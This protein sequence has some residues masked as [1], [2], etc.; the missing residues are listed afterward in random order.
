[1]KQIITLLTLFMCFSLLNAQEK[2]RLK[3]GKTVLDSLLVA[4]VHVINKSTNIGTISND[5]GSFEIPVY[6]GDTL[7]FSHI[8]YKD[9]FVVITDKTINKLNTNIE[10]EEKTFLLKEI[11]LEKQRSI[12]YQD[13]EITSYKGPVVNAKKLNLPYANTFAEKD[14]SIL[15]FRS[16][17][18]ISLGNLISAINGT[19]KREKQLKEMALEDTYLEKI[20]KHFTDD[21]FITD[22]KI[23][24]IYI[25]Q[26]LND[27]I[28]KNIISIFKR[29]NK[30]D[31]I[32]LL[33]QESKLFTHKIVNEDLYLTNY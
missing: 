5:N 26:F 33:M 12:F 24:K 7:F 17:A 1:M 6:V 30:L 20:R 3:I 19:K 29:E 32:K 11:V 23:K 16:G 14:K 4:N 2:R 25:N 9:K 21:F 10:L 22:L 27:C 15:K 28:D 8:K 13:P 18:S 31:V